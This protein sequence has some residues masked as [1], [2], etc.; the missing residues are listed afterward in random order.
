M[1]IPVLDFQFPE[2]AEN[3]FLF[4]KQPQQTN[5]RAKTT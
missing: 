2:A 3:K 4:F 1:V 5:I